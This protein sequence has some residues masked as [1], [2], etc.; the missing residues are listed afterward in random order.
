M[1]IKFIE[2]GHLM[3]KFWFEIK[4]LLGTNNMSSGYIKFGWCC[5]IN[6][7][8]ANSGQDLAKCF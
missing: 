5:Y 3:T 4:L 1:T 6:G 7:Y 2:L 8:Y